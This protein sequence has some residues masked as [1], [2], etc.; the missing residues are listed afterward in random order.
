M[1]ADSGPT[2]PLFL[3]D[4]QH[5]LVGDS[6]VLQRLAEV[7]ETSP[8]HAHRFN[9]AVSVGSLVLVFGHGHDGLQG[10]SWPEVADE[11]SA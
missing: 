10:I 11:P 9:A 1:A 4:A 6:T 5:R 8:G 3:G 2:F 7:R